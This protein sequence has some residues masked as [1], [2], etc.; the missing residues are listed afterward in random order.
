EK[1]ENDDE[2]SIFPKKVG[3]VFIDDVSDSKKTLKNNLKKLSLKIKSEK[4]NKPHLPFDQI[5]CAHLL[6]QMNKVQDIFDFQIVRLRFPDQLSY[7]VNKYDLKWFTHQISTFESSE[8]GKKYNIDYWIVITSDKIENNLY[9]IE[10]EKPRK[11][12]TTSLNWEGVNSP[13]S[14]FEYL[15]ISVL[16]C[17]LYFINR[18]FYGRLGSHPMLLTKGCIY[19]FTIF[20]P[21]RRILVSNPYLCSICRKQMK[22]LEDI[23]HNNT[24]KNI[25]LCEGINKILAREWMGDA[26]KKDSPLYNIKKNYGYDIN[27]NSGFNKKW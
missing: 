21:D 24:S 20:K 14:L 22:N 6:L 10:E 27:R 17:R 11:A 18:E 7:S 8:E 12:I 16:M 1:L 5:A 26:E 9:Y 23:I 15:S 4:G 19:D 3:I 2:T 25:K 13:P